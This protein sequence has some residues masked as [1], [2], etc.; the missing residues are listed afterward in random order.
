MLPPPS[1]TTTAALLAVAA[2]LAAPAA[3]AALLH[4]SSY[5]SFAD[6]PFSALTFDYFL[7]ENFESGSL[8]VPGVTASAGIV[9]GP[10]NLTDSVDADD[11]SIDGSGVAGHSWFSAG[12]AGAI[13]FTFDSGALGGLPTHAGLVW[14]DVG[15]TNAQNGIGRV[16]FEA[17]DA[18]GN[19]LGEI[20]PTTVG[21][22]NAS[23]GT[24]EDHFFGVIFEGGI[25][26]IV[27]TSLDSMDWE[28]DHLQFGR[29]AI[30]LDTSG[31]LTLAGALL[32]AAMA[33]PS[34]R[35]QARKDRTPGAMLGQ[36]TAWA[37]SPA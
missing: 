7:L 4:S 28:M 35:R 17:F 37:P 12:M 21:D 33:F 6:S 23:G 20:G 32:A 36:S 15:F 19:S 27:L 9:A 14:T 1:R 11:G 34:T 3:G 26:Q 24:A 10:G 16:Q 5:A 8:A 31:T 2:V 30:P 18:R 25:A 13:V 22:G 29:R